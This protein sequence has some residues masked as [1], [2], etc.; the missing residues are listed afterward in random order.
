M[1]RKLIV[2]R[3][4]PL[5]IML[6]AVLFGVGFPILGVAW[7]LLANAKTLDNL[8][9]AFLVAIPGLVALAVAFFTIGLATFTA[10]REAGALG[11]DKAQP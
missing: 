4:N 1:K 8:A 7:H 3:W 11:E 6:V 5:T 2:V 10:A 9:L